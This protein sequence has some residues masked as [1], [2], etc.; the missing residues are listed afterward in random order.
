VHLLRAADVDF[1]TWDDWRRYDAW[2]IREGEKLGK[3][4]RKLSTLDE[5]MAIVRRLRSEAAA[6]Q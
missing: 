1:V 2:E 5:V 3:V 4:R 6:P